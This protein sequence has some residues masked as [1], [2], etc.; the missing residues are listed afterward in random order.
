MS[1]PSKTIVPD[2]G[3]ISPEMRRKNVVLPAPFGP[4][5]ERSSPRRTPT[6]TCLTAMRLPNA[7]VR[8][9]V[10]SRTESGIPARVYHAVFVTVKDW[11]VKE[12]HDQ[13]DRRQHRRVRQLLLD[14]SAGEDSHAPRPGRARRGG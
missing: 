14:G 1:R 4:M 10:S 5:I 11:Q 12:R 8:S 6:D 9:R 13:S 2:V 3:V 7:R